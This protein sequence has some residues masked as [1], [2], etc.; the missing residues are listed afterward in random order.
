MSESEL[1]KQ[2]SSKIESVI[3][4]PDNSGADL[5][6]IG[7]TVVSRQE[8]VEAFKDIVKQEG[9]LE[10]HSSGG[11]RVANPAP[12]GLSSFA[13]TTFVL[14]VINAHGRHVTTPNIVVGLAFFYGGLCQLLAGMWEFVAGNTF[15][16]TAFSSYGG[17]WMAWGAI[18]VDSF[19]ILTAY[20]NDP[21]ALASAVG[22]FLTGWFI[23]TFL[24]VICS[25]R[26]TV[27]NFLLFFSLDL[28][29]LFLAI[30]SYTGSVGVTKAGGWAGIVSAFIAW[31]NALTGLISKHN[32]YFNL[33]QW[34]I[35]GYRDKKEEEKKNS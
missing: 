8:F 9:I 30:G 3:Y 22:F 31:Y 28:A 14:S 16:A 29:F 23:F 33:T 34:D 32:A 12:L 10:Q 1:P 25:S 13:L 4:S 2:D 35:S 18:Y 5:I 17:F 6:H 15:G 7:S 19:G 26:T 20:Q 24:L 27:Q 11:F 21:E